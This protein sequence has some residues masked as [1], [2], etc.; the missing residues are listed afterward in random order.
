MLAKIKIDD[1]AAIMAGKNQF[2]IH[3]IEINPADLTEDER[4][5]LVATRRYNSQ[6]GASEYLLYLWDDRVQDKDLYA[7]APTP[8]EVGRILRKRIKIKEE[9]KREEKSR[10]EKE[11]QNLLNSPLENCIS[12]YCSYTPPAEEVVDEKGEKFYYRPKVYHVIEWIDDERL[13][14]K[15]EQVKEYCKKKNEEEKGKCDEKIAAKKEEIEA[16]RKELRERDDARYDY[17]GEFLEKH[18]TDSQQ[19]RWKENVLPKN[20]LNGLIKDFTFSS[21]EQFPRFEMITD[22]IVEKHADLE[23]YEELDQDCIEYYTD[24]AYELD[25]AEWE[26]L[27]KIKEAIQKEWPDAEVEAK[28]HIAEYREEKCYERLAIQVTVEHHGFKFVRSYGVVE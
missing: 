11:L 19:E 23:E 15:L 2:G 16:R 25:E 18:G 8:D 24:D 28:T 22:D 17:I 26:T 4:R 21:L 10:H 20:E 1:E 5:E 3:E 13:Q 9:K 7:L 27:K 12:D 6:E 14:E